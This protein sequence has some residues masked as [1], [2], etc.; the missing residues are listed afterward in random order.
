MLPWVEVPS[1]PCSSPPR[2][3]YSDRSFSLPQ[4]HNRAGRQL[5]FLLVLSA[6]EALTFGF[7]TTVLALRL[8]VSWCPH[9]NLHIRNAEDLDELLRIEYDFRATLM[10]LGLV[11][12]YSFLRM[13]RLGEAGRESAPKR[14]R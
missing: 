12:L 2:R 3:W 9:E 7:G 1:S 5:P 6:A 4:R 8:L 13:P 11:L 10:T 14:V